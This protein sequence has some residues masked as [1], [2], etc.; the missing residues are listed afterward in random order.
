MGLPWK[1]GSISTARWTGCALGDVLKHCGIDLEAAEDK[2]F[3]GVVGGPPQESLR[4]LELEY[5][6]GLC[7]GHQSRDGVLARARILRRG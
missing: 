6:A 3:E 2:G 1:N 7:H 5:S 4:R